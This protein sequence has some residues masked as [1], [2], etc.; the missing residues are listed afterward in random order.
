MPI[1]KYKNDKNEESIFQGNLAK[2]KGKDVPKG[3]GINFTQKRLEFGVF[4]EKPFTIY[5]FYPG[6]GKLTIVPNINK[7]IRT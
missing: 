5:R 2:E 1:T 7:P 6:K 3:V 4:G